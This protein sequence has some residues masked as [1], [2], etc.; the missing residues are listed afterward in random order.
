MTGVKE[1]R[2]SI[3]TD[4]KTWKEIQKK[5]KEDGRS[6]NDYMVRA[7]LAGDLFSKINHIID[8]LE[9]LKREK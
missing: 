4:E 8:L 7:A 2:G 5:A 1:R 9:E 3:Y 6:V